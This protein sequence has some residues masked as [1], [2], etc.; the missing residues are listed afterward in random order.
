MKVIDIYNERVKENVPFFSFEYFPPKTE[1]G[2]QNLFSRMAHMGQFGPQWIDVTWGAGGSTSAA[3]LEICSVA[4]SKIGLETMMHLTCTNMPVEKIT[5]ALEEA[6]ANGIKNILALRGDPPRGE[7][8]KKI[9]GG[10]AHAV[11]LVKH[12]RKVHGDYFGIVVAG[13]PEG[14]VDANSYEED[15]QHLKEKIDA[16]ADAV[17]TQLFYDVDIFL[18]FVEDCRRIGITAPIIPGIMPIQTYGGFQ[19]MTTFCKTIIPDHV[20]LALDP[21]QHNDEAVREYG[22][23]L[24][25]DMCRRMMK[26]GILSFH[27]YTLN[28]EKTVLRIL[29]GLDMISTN[30]ERPVP[31][32]LLSKREKED[33]RP[34]FW[35]N[36][37]QSYI[38]RTS[39]WDE[40][41]NGRWG[42]S[43]SPAFGDLTDYHLTSLHAPVPRSK[44]LLTEDGSFMYGDELKSPTEVFD[45][46]VKYLQ[47]KLPFLPWFDRPLA[48]ES[49]EIRTD[50]ILINRA[51]FLTINSQPQV[52][53]LPSDDPVFGWGEKGGYVYQKAYLEFFCSPESF[54]ELRKV[55]ENYPSMTFHA[56]NKA[57]ESL[58]NTT[59]NEVAAVTWGVFPCSEIKQPTVVDPESFAVW[60]DEAFALWLSN[61]ANHYA[62]GSPSAH[63]LNDIIASYW[64]VNLYDNDYVNGNIFA[65]F[66]DL[67]KEGG[68]H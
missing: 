32:R 7:D 31:W 65:P 57:G 39:S 35:S 9:E 5:T 33:V 22:V 62:E 24:A 43:R 66:K 67:L 45:V 13:Y 29:E 20:R 26:A 16:G 37:P 42:D 14:H 49:S 12:I 64:L 44:S 25:V 10:F 2:K 59:R 53:G 40:F 1:Q 38:F 54:S 36:R 6:K 8:W 41:P 15:L 60:K 27:F 51:G 58:T 28:L 55:L 47:G 11:D 30:I 68:V 19:R 61:W 50:L 48:P 4:Q 21:I 34:I 46:F 52:N 63:L 56:M 3:T 17:I 23:R 18:K